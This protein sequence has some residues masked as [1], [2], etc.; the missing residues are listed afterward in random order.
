MKKA[1]LELII[2]LCMVVV[3][4]G[5]IKNCQERAEA[6]AETSADAKATVEA[7]AET[8]A[9]Q[10]EQATEAVAD[11]TGDAE[12]DA[13]FER[14]YFDALAK[15]ADEGKLYAIDSEG[16]RSP[17]AFKNYD[18]FSKFINDNP[19]YLRAHFSY[20]VKGRGFNV[21]CKPTKTPIE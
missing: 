5:G 18:D 10:T 20:D 16:K 1:Y 2:A 7:S 13:Y 21:N 12:M 8:A 19:Q 15:N 6:T 4:I 11:S 3:A 17:Q 14:I 9:S